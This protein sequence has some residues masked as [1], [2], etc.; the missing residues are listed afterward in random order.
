M[1]VECDAPRLSEIEAGVEFERAAN[2]AFGAFQGTDNNATRF[3]LGSAAILGPEHGIVQYELA[4][5][6]APFGL[7]HHGFMVVTLPALDER[8]GAKPPQTAFVGIEQ[9]T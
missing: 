2:V 9:R 4:A 7:Q 5:G 8:S 1:L 3:L 6:S